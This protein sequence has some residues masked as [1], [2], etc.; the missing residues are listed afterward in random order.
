M[1]DKSKELTRK[2]PKEFMF[3]VIDEY[4]EGVKIVHNEE[5]SDRRWSVDHFIVF[6]Y[7]NKFYS[8][9]YSVGATENQDES[10]YEYDGDMIECDVMESYQETVTKYRPKGST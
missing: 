3:N 6:S 1:S 7:E 4:Q 2:F 9:N 5:S 8:S 10:P